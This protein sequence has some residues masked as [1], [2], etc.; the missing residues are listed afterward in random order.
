MTLWTKTNLEAVLFHVA[1]SNLSLEGNLVHLDPA[2][3]TFAEI[4]DEMVGCA[5]VLDEYVSNHYKAKVNMIL[6]TTTTMRQRL[7]GFTNLMQH[8]I[9]PNPDG[10]KLTFVRV[11]I[12]VKCL[13]HMCYEILNRDDSTMYKFY[14]VKLFVCAAAEQ[15]ALCEDVPWFCVDECAVTEEQHTD[16]KVIIAALIVFTSVFCT[17]YVWFV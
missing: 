15:L 17:L 11:I 12:I 2:L 5:D 10:E 14:V 8:L 4:L 3:R 13:M 16:V 6:R 7:I 9:P 1:H